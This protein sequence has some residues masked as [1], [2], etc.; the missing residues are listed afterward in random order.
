[1][2][3]LN[4]KVERLLFTAAPEPTVNFALEILPLTAMSTFSEEVV[5]DT[6]KNASGFVGYQAISEINVSL[7][8][9]NKVFFFDSDDSDPNTMYPG[10]FTD[11]SYGILG[12]DGINPFASPNPLNVSFSE[13]K[14]IAGWANAAV[15]YQGNTTLKQDY[16]RY[17]AKSITGGYA[18]A[19]LFSN[20]RI[21]LTG[22][23]NMDIPFNTGLYTALNNVSQT[24]TLTSDAIKT[25][26]SLVTGLLNMAKYPNGSPSNTRGNQFLSDLASQSQ[27][28][29]QSKRFWV[30]FRP[31]DA[32][33][34]Q[35]TYIPK[36]GDN[37]IA[38]NN[39]DFL[40]TNRIMNRTYKI[41]LKMV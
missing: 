11:A 15:E 34:L 26:E 8:K 5:F 22:V 32:L 12:S 16:I 17:T 3:A 14:V 6:A 24:R 39:N 13:S 20:E 38:K 9:W 37:Q 30:Y 7:T 33:A 2:T 18:L 35:L 10:S 31:G 36:E 25:T 23:S 29:T 1:M 21:L 40:G 19:D 41:Y 28:E 4:N 27:T